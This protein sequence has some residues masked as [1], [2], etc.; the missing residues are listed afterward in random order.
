MQLLSCLVYHTRPMTLINFKRSDR[1]SYRNWP[2]RIA[3]YAG[4][5]W[6]ARVARTGA[7]RVITFGAVVAMTALKTPISKRS[8]TASY[9]E[10]G[11]IK[12]RTFLSFA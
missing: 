2:T 6:C 5:P 3:R 8:A 9:N 10:L 12:K 11:Y 4:P 1:S 7:V